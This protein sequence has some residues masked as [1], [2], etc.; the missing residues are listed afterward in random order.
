M[1]QQ[2]ET[3]TYRH[4]VKSRNNW[5]VKFLSLKV[6]TLR[7]SKRPF[8]IYRSVRSNTPEDLNLLQHRCASLK[9]REV[10]LVK[11]LHA[12]SRCA[13]PVVCLNY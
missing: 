7:P 9:F 5:M 1:S 12:I 6:K 11:N 13:I 10:I 2:L 4:G 8:T 3:V